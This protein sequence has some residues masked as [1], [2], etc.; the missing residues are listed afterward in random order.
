MKERK[1]FQRIK[2]DG[3]KNY[4]I[5]K[6]IKKSTR[7]SFYKK[8]NEVF[9]MKIHFLHY[10]EFD[11]IIKENLSKKIIFFDFFPGWTGLMFQRPH[12]MAMQFAENNYLYFY[13]D[14]HIIGFKKIQDGLYLTNRYDLFAQM[15][16]IVFHLYS[17]DL[18]LRGID[19]VNKIENNEQFVLYEYID[20]LSLT[21]KYK[22][23][24][25]YL[26]LHNDLLKNEYTLVAATADLL[27]KEAE[28]K[29]VNLPI[30]S[31]NAV[32]LE[33][34]KNFKKE[35]V[36]PDEITELVE[37]NRP[38]IGYF[39][40]LSSW[41]DYELLKKCLRDR[42]QYEFLLFGVNT[43]KEIVKLIEEEFSNIT[44]LP[45]VEYD[46]LPIFS[47]YFDVAMLPFKL[48]EITLATSPV[49]IFEYMAQGHPI[50]STALPECRKYKAIF[51]SETYDEFLNNLDKALTKKND[52][53]YIQLLLETAKE[54]T[55]KAR[56][57]DIKEALE[58]LIKNK[59]LG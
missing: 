45:T 19:Y 50:V 3:L 58:K 39:G 16:G 20:D 2:E 48:N 46:K 57:F 11:A 25:R 55:W 53:Q 37:K 6:I 47:S 36:V 15:K 27:Y 5:K 40:A 7:S 22:K 51:V 28:E 52:P 32:T 1:S 12:H 34:F 35:N 41:F 30:L 14:P 43:E 18:P 38:I 49:K 44:I 42:P 29:C 54:N 8:I 33:R 24:T 4:L 17:A 10:K 56:F 9:L 26:N 13:Y 31:P 21:E 59:S 23:D